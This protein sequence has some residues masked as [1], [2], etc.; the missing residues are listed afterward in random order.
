MEIFKNIYIYL[1]IVYYIHLLYI[2]LYII[3]LY[4]I[5]ILNIYNL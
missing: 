1:Y 4:I 5:C 2:V 3:I